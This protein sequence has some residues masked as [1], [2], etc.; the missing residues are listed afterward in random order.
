[1]FDKYS[2]D[3]SK[4][5]ESETLLAG[6]RLELQGQK[7]LVVKLQTG[8]QDLEEKNANLVREQMQLE[9]EITASR[10]QMESLSGNSSF[11]RNESEKKHRS[12]NTQSA[13]TEVSLLK[14]RSAELERE[15]AMK[16]QLIEQL[17]K[18]PAES[19][20]EMLRNNY[21]QLENE[22][23]QLKQRGAAAPNS[24]KSEIQSR[25][26]HSEV[27][28]SEKRELQ[29]EVEELKL[30]LTLKT[31]EC[32]DLKNK[33]TSLGSELREARDL[34]ASKLYRTSEI[35]ERETERDV[36][37]L[38]VSQS[39]GAEFKRSDLGLNTQQPT[40]PAIKRQHSDTIGRV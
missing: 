24:F 13:E 17:S 22:L 38:S 7:A 33:V 37:G 30:D 26:T 8:N 18:G 32:D 10:S 1:M 20:Y 5:D 39:L 2:E 9:S 21:F 29:E 35:E 31:S 40:G 12:T 6:V 4:F 16:E 11:T 23:I 28:A 15:L 14:A 3:K 25:I 34:L 27:A 19:E 36:C